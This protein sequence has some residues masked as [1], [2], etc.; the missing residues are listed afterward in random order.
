[1]AAQSSEKHL[2]HFLAAVLNIWRCAIPLDLHPF[3][4]N[5]TKWSLRILLRYLAKYAHPRNTNDISYALE[6][7]LTYASAF[8][9]LLCSIFNNPSFSSDCRIKGYAMKSIYSLMDY[10]NIHTHKSD[11]MKGDTMDTFINNLMDSLR[12]TD[13]NIEYFSEH[14][15]DFIRNNDEYIQTDV[16]LGRYYS[17]LCLEKIGSD[18]KALEWILLSCLSR[19]NET[20]LQPTH[21]NVFSREVI[22]STLH[23]LSKKILEVFDY[24]I[25]ENIF[26]RVILPGLRFSTHTFLIIRLLNLMYTMIDERLEEVLGVELFSVV[27]ECIKNKDETV[28]ISSLMCLSQLLR[29]PSIR[30]KFKEEEANALVDYCLELVCQTESDYLVSCLR[31]IIQDLSSVLVSGII[32]V[33]RR[34]ID[35]SVKFLDHTS[36][37]EV[38][39]NDSR[40]ITERF[41]L[42]DSVKQCIDLMCD[43]ILYKLDLDELKEALSIV[44]PLVVRCCLISDHILLCEGRIISS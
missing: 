12:L 39:Q 38:D 44:Q 19:L 42:I 25:I 23:I 8:W 5:T 32:S 41:R 24:Q 17:I 40:E 2:I 10:S 9:H 14:P 11:I 37:L 30:E 27:R 15:Q 43:L 21:I 3:I 26:I 22:Y 1:M 18:R 4:V 7:S 33:F 20:Q 13:S 6:W 34:L 35:I 29:Y 31:L 16:D 28:S 36:S